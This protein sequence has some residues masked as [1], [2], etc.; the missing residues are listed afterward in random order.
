MQITLDDRQYERLRQEAE[1]T[2]ASIA[3]LIRRAVAGTFGPLSPQDRAAL[4]RQ[5]AGGWAEDAGED[6]SAYLESFRGPGLGH[7]LRSPA[8]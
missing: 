6:R 5:A 4:L 2:G 8:T 1:R 3:E 7:R